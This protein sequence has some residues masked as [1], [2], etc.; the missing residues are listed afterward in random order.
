[1]W[2]KITS[3]GLDLTKKF[4]IEGRNEYRV[5]ILEPQKEI[6]LIVFVISLISLFFAF[7]IGWPKF[8]DYLNYQ[9]VEAKLMFSNIALELLAENSYVMHYITKENQRRQWN[10]WT[11]FA[12]ELN[13]FYFSLN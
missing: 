6:Q 13:Y 2:F 1:M 7:L 12:L 8:V 3:Q 9:L 4:I 10:V 5:N 11:D